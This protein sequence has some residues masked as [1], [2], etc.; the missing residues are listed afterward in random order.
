M[1]LRLFVRDKGSDFSV[2]EVDQ[3]K[4]IEELKNLGFKV[5]MIKKSEGV[6]EDL[7]K[8]CLRGGEGVF[9]SLTYLHDLI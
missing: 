4:M 2:E 7:K 3:L 9:M 5:N 1:Y 6:V 8:E